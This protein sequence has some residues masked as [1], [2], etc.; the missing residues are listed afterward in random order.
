[1]DLAKLYGEEM[2]INPYSE[3]DYACPYVSDGESVWRKAYGHAL[4]MKVR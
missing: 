1:M 4:L 2:V 3:F